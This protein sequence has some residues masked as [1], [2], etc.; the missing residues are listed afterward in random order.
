RRGG[1][2][3]GDGAPSDGRK[4]AADGA[5]GEEAGDGTDA[6]RSKPADVAAGAGSQ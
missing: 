1:A 4:R 2:G 5:A 3:R 6:K